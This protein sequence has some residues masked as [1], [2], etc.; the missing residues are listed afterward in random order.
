MENNIPMVIAT[1]PKEIIHLGHD[2]LDSI[3]EA[4]GI[5]KYAITSDIIKGVNIPQ[6]KYNKPLR[7]IIIRD[8]S[9]YVCFISFKS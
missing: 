5:H 6:H 4:T 1:K 9:K 8:Q 2:H 7:L 3:K